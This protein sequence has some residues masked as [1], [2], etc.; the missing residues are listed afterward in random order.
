MHQGSGRQKG[1]LRRANDGIGKKSSRAFAKPGTAQVK[2]LGQGMSQR[3]QLN[4]TAERSLEMTFPVWCRQNTWPQTQTRGL[5]NM[6]PM[7][8]G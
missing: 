2:L 8:P 5:E 3:K 7:P 6:L 1:E 4:H